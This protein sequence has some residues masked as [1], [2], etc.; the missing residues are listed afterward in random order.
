V[1]RASCTA[2]FLL[3]VVATT[4]FVERLELLLDH[5][6]LFNGIDYTG[7]HIMSGGLLVVAGAL[8]R[9]A[10]MAVMNAARR[11]RATW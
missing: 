1:A 4:V 8:F 3:L 7:V 6:T 11:P 10:V 9:N 5:H 2:A